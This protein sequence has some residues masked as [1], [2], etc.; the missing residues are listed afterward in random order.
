MHRSATGDSSILLLLWDLAMCVCI[1]ES[2]IA[3]LN[4][5]SLF[6]TIFFV[7]VYSQETL[8]LFQ[9]YIFDLL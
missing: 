6:V 7:S 1:L 3:M 9:E 4:A 5:I 2:V 8:V